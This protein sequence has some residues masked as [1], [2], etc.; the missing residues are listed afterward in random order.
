MNQIDE[1]SLEEDTLYR[2]GYCQDGDVLEIPAVDPELGTV[3]YTLDQGVTLAPN[4]RRQ[5]MI[6]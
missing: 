6:V 1:Q 4:F 3:F 2:V 5:T